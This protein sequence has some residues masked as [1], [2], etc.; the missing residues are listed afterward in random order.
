MRSQNNVSK[1][2][3]TKYSSSGINVK[4]KK[5]SVTH[6]IYA[7]TSSF[8]KQTV[9]RSPKLLTAIRAAMK[10]AREH[11]YDDSKKMSASG[12][13]VKDKKR[14]VTYPIYTSTPI[15]CKKTVSC[16]SPKLLTAVRAE[17]KKAR[18]D[19]Y[20]N[21]ASKKIE[22]RT[23]INRSI[24]KEKIKKNHVKII[25]GVQNMQRT[26]QSNG[27]SSDSYGTISMHQTQNE[28]VQV[29]IFINII[30][31]ISGA[32]PKRK[33]LGTINSNIAT[34]GIFYGNQHSSNPHRSS[35]QNVN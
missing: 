35:F 28:S 9:P 10:K 7:S 31:L 11:Q 34:Q 4:A 18:E 20:N 26:L 3:E 5:R 21:S 24:K 30:V 19:H 2:T 6:P 1:F 22:H 33:V 27:Q 13:S 32:I 25:K 15:F 16:R 14:S 17:M 12:I 29:K 8:S 23:I